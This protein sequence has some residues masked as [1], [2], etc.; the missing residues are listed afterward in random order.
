M[1]TSIF[2]GVLWLFI[3]KFFPPIINFCVFAYTARILAPEDF[4]LIA[5]ALSI[6]YITSSFM[7]SGWRAAIIKYQLT[8]KNS[9]SS[10]FWLNFFVSFLLMLLI[11]GFAYVSVFEFQ[12][13][14]F[15]AVLMLLSIKIIFDG[16]FH[17]LNTVLLQQQLYSLLAI[18]TVVSSIA[19]AFIIIL[20][21]MS[22]FGIWALV[23][24]QIIL[25]IANFVAVL[26]PTRKYLAFSLNISV[27]K[28]INSFAIYTTL[29]E[30]L[31][32][33]MDH[34]DSLIIGTILGKRELG[35]FNVAK[36]LTTIMNNIFIS[37]VAEINFPMLAAKQKDQEVFKK[38]YLLSIYLSVV[39]LFPLFVF[40][41]ISSSDIIV[42]LFTDKWITATFPFQVFC[43]MSLFIILGVPQKHIIILNDHAQW[44]FKLQLKLSLLIIPLTTLA[45]FWGVNYLLM[46]LMISK[47]IY[48]F[49]SMYKSCQLLSFQIKTYFLN[50]LTP[51]L[52]CFSAAAIL[53]LLDQFVARHEFIF[54]NIIWAILLYFGS[55]FVLLSLFSRQKLI[56]IATLFFP[57][58]KVLVFLQ[59]IKN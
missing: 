40:C 46:M 50:F 55:Y 30:S 53:M 25:S 54:V 58:N 56:M 31:T 13:E 45:A 38:S 26:L 22:D 5:L 4:G 49:C 36:R 39:C 1:K 52:C 12:T 8:D 48:W 37:T 11:N 57:N 10:I 44:W 59:V 17:T 2:K 51:M 21:I 16:L 33:I 28:K 29:T 47:V 20:L 41:A 19:S 14:V 42:F 9:I 7:P 27:Y 3:S 43:I 6:I 34:Y 24:V 23:W 35:F 15:N 18:R 32:S